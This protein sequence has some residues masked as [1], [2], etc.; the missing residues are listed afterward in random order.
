MKENLEERLRCIEAGEYEVPSAITYQNI[1]FQLVIASAHQYAAP[2]VDEPSSAWLY[3]YRYHGPCS[4]LHLTY[5]KQHDS[6]HISIVMQRQ[7]L[8]KRSVGNH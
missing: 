6:S 8:R 3:Q 1:E 7:R 2:V 4:P 5:G